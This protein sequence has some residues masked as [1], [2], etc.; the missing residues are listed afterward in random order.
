MNIKKLNILIHP[1]SYLHAIIEFNDGMIKLIAHDTTMQIQFL[2]QF[3]IK[4]KN[5]ISQKIKHK[6]T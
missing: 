1:K 2:I 3:I 6:I 5:N 4:E